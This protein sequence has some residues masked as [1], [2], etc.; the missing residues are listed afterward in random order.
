MRGRSR[1]RIVRWVELASLWEACAPKPG[2][3]NRRFDFHDATLPDFLS[4]AV[5]AAESL[6]GTRRWSVGS[7]VHRAVRARAAVVGSNTNLG[8]LLL[9]APLAMAASSGPRGTL[10]ARTAETL[11]SMDR[12]DARLVYEAIRL[13]APGGLGRVDR[14]DVAEE[15]PPSLLD[16]MK[17]AA[18]RDSV[19]REYGTDFALTFDLVVPE[20]HKGLEAGL[21]LA[22][23]VVR[24]YLVV[25]ASVPDTL[26]SRK[27]GI[28][29]ARDVSRRAA[30]LLETASKGLFI[31]PSG[32]ERFDGE[33]RAFGNRLNP[34]TTAD[35]TTAGLFVLLAEGPWSEAELLARWKEASA[36][37][38]LPATAA[39]PDAE[40]IRRRTVLRL[41]RRREI[42]LGGR[43][44]LMGVVNVTPDSFF[45]GSRVGCVDAAVARARD[46]IAAGA[47]L[48]DIGARS[49]RPGASEI[50]EE[51]E[52]RRLIDVVAA[53]RSSLPEAV[54]SVDTSRASV[55]QEAI[56]SGADLI[57]DVTALADPDMAAVIAAAGIPVVLMHMKGTPRTMREEARYDDLL[58]EVIAFL[59]DRVDVAVRSGIP[60]DRILLDPGIGFGKRR[61][62]NLTL[63]R[64]IGRLMELGFP[65]LIGHSRKAFLDPAGEGSPDPAE[66]LEETLAVTAFCAERGVEILRV[67]DIASNRRLLRTLEAVRRGV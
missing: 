64:E 17:E 35:L 51:E 2:N 27:E 62:H 56:R 5:V 49:T 38:R 40:R 19:A 26:I 44:L 33:L 9:L 7:L 24:A 10:R 20:L 45:E 55:A 39:F 34:G 57:N 65:L 32:L 14:D 42:E 58:G 66:R 28:E 30:E 48:L 16:A 18:L 63:L 21:G 15:A 31:A 1:A 12:E 23:A 36:G 54:L 41:P 46:M 59:T 13:A 4:S 37:P 67:H 3:V 60:R 43:T 8:I 11:R 47:D 61:V 52:K 22:D 50:S 53:V 6:R 29:R 25:L